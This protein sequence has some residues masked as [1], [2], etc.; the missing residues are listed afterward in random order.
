MTLKAEYRLSRID[1]SANQ[2]SHYAM[3]GR[4]QRDWVDS[5]I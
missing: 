2:F 3:T 5:D 4:G 1:A